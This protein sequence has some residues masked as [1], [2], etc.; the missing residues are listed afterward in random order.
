MTESPDGRGIVPGDTLRPQPRAG[1][2]GPVENIKDVF[3]ANRDAVERAACTLLPQFHGRGLGLSTGFFPL[4]EHPR[5]DTWLITLDPFQAGIEQLQ[6]GQFSARE[7][8]RC[9]MDCPKH[10]A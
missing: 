9:G 6:R 3:D 5:L 4:D 2:G 1:R 8:G 10:G 7:R